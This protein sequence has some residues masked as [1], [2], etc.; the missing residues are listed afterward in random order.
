MLPWANIQDEMELICLK[1]SVIKAR[2]TS[3]HPLCYNF[4]GW[5]FFRFASKFLDG[6]LNRFHFSTKF[7]IKFYYEIFSFAT[8][9]MRTSVPNVIFLQAPEFSG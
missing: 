1:R 4:Y 6:T 2:L 3:S 9:S 5:F 8:K 7:D